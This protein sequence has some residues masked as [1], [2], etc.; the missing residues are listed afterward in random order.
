MV[1]RHLIDSFD[2]V[3]PG[4]FM[5]KAKTSDGRYP[6]KQLGCPSDYVNLFFNDCFS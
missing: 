5:D 1:I 6:K 2:T 3:R 4:D